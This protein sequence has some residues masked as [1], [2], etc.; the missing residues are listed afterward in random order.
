MITAEESRNERALRHVAYRAHAAP[1]VHNTQPWRFRIGPHHLTIVADRL[2]QLPVLD[3]TGRQLT[4]S[5]GCALFNA[6]V[7]AAVDG[8]TVRV[9]RLPEGPNSDVLAL[10]ELCEPG[11]QGVDVPVASADVRDWEVAIQTRHTNRRK[12]SDLPV[13]R[14]V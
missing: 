10:L 4:L 14:S 3:P 6:R 12:F 9:T 1:S 13:P 2:R 11:S 8:L 7:A 5:C